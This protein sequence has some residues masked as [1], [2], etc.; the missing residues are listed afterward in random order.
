ML[1]SVEKQFVLLSNPKTGTTALEKA[2]V[3][4]AD[5]RTG[6]SPKWK[7]IRYDK[8]KDIFGDY[9]ERQGCQIYAV[10]RHPIDTLASWFK[11]RSRKALARPRHKGAANYTGE[12]TFAKFVEEWASDSPPPRARVPVSVKWCMTRRGTPA[13][14]NFYRYEDISLLAAKLSEHVGEALELPKKNVSPERDVS[15]DRERIAALP[16]MKPFIE[17]YESI[18]FVPRP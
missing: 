17:M 16:K 8:F 13:P 6:G 12:I 18:Q 1:A 4:Y 11:Y 7:H 9:F 10:A 2:F 14:I 5:I 3:K 15:I